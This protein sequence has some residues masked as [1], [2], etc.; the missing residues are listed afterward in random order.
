MS[1]ADAAASSAVDGA[2]AGEPTA[3]TT[4]SEPGN[5]IF[6]RDVYSFRVSLVYIVYVGVCHNVWCRLGI[7]PFRNIIIVFV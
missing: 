6:G 7:D 5:I 1:A 4:T 2:A 3:A